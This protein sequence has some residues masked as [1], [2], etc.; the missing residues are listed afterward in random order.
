MARGERGLPNKRFAPR[1]LQV[2]P[3][4]ERCAGYASSLLDRRAY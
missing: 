3:S 2:P 4:L 1:T